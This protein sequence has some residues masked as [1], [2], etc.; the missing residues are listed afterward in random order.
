MAFG[1]FIKSIKNAKSSVTNKVDDPE[2]MKGDTF[3]H[4]NNDKNDMIIAEDDVGD[5]NKEIGD[6]GGEDDKDDTGTNDEFAGG[7]STQYNTNNDSSSANVSI[8]DTYVILC[9]L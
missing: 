1:N 5:D 7:S 2:N 4:G 8:F 3:E 9:L 6:K